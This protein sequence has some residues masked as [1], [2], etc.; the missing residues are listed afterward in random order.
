MS[1]KAMTYPN[2]STTIT[3]SQN[4]SLTLTKWGSRELPPLLRRTTC[5]TCMC[6]EWTSLK[7]GVS[8]AKEEHAHD[9]DHHS[10]GGHHSHAAMFGFYPATREA[11]GTSWQPDSAPHEGI[12]GMF[13][14]WATMLHGAAFGIYDDQGG[15]RGDEKA[16]STSDLMFAGQRPLGPGTFGLRAMISL[17]PLMGKRGYPLLLQT[18]GGA[19][20]QRRSMGW[21]QAFTWIGPRHVDGHQH[22]GPG[23]ARY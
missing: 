6:M 13:G 10:H 20:T 4:R 18:N 16:F 22:P 8:L 9:T 3:T 23:W 5:I 19:G 11:F 17:D 14:K 2:T 12:S 1:I 15:R 7:E 21:P